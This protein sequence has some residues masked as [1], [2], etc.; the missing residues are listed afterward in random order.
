MR[1]YGERLAALFDGGARVLLEGPLGA[2]KTTLVQEVLQ[3]M[4][5]TEPVT[6]PTFDLLH[7]YE[8]PDLKVYHADLYRLEHR[9]ELLVLDLPGPEE[10]GILLLAEW[11]S[12]LR[13][14]YPERFDIEIENFGGER[15]QV[16]MTAWGENPVNRLRDWAEEAQHGF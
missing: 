15:R 8:R 4:G 6:S 1:I 9:E 2:G 12:L 14:D 5:V 13:E 11:G 10:P 16:S 3:A 7:I